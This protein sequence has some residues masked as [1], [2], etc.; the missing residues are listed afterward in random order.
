MR[1]NEIQVYNEGDH[2]LIVLQIPGLNESITL[3][4]QARQY[5]V[6][7]EIADYPGT[8]FRPMWE[9]A[10]LHRQA[11]LLQAD[12]TVI[13]QARPPQKAGVGNGGWESERLIFQF[14]RKEADYAVGVAVRI[15]GNLYCHALK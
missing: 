1:T 8:T 9:A 5:T 14:P 12:G 6:Q 15:G 7:L 2:E 4:T 10:E 3:T 13:S 11:W